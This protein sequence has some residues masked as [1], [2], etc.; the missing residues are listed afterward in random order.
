M[1]AGR[2]K[3]TKIGRSKAENRRSRVTSELMRGEGG[4]DD[5]L[6][7]RDEAL[8]SSERSSVGSRSVTTMR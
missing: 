5:E 6:S 7:G 8:N 2:R 3:E 1:E 4:Q